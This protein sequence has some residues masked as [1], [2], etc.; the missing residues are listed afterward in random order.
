[1]VPQCTHLKVTSPY[2]LKEILLHSSTTDL[3]ENLAGIKA[4]VGEGI[5][6]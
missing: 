5:G 1:M 2:D 4:G 3:K 6:V